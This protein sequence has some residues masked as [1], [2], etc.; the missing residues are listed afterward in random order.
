MTTLAPV[1]EFRADRQT[2]K[3]PFVLH[4]TDLPPVIPD[5]WSWE[6]GD[7]TG[8]S[9]QNPSHIYM[10]DGAY[11]VGLMV[12]NRYG[13][14]SIFKNAS[15]VPVVT[16]PWTPAPETVALTDSTHV[17]T[18]STTAAP[19]GTKSPLSLIA[20]LLALIG[21]LLVAGSGGRR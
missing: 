16:K 19:A 5:T 7:G 14:D 8:S 13:S 18:L 20:A 2:G 9:E 3:A 12:S 21:G 10:N 11:D 4:F 6:F 1:A 15:S 17:T